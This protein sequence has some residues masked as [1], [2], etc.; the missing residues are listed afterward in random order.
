MVSATF[1]S[2]PGNTTLPIL[3][4]STVKLG[5]TADINALATITVVIVGL[6]VLFAAIIL[7]R[8]DKHR[9]AR[10]AYQENR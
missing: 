1:V 7:T 2:G 6:C 5:V 3:I 9:Y 4:W 8:A 10:L